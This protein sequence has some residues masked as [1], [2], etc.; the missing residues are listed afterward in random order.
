VKSK[1]VCVS[2][3]ILFPLA[4]DA[5]PMS[6]NNTQQREIKS[7][8]KSFEILRYIKQLNGAKVSELTELTDLTKGTVHTHLS[9]LMNLEYVTQNDSEYHLTCQFIIEGEY[10]RNHNP[11]FQAGWNEINKLA[12]ETGEFVHLMAEHAGGE[13]TLHDAQGEN[14]IATDYRIQMRQE[15]EHL[16][17]T[18]SGKAILANLPGERVSEIIDRRGIP[19]KTYNTITDREKLNTELEQIREQGYAT[20]EEEEI[21]GIVAVGVP[22]NMK[23]GTVLAALSISAPSSR[24]TEKKLYETYPEQ[25]KIRKQK[26][27]EKFDK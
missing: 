27:E 26:I 25:L 18:A 3:N 5:S 20:N 16:H 12:I 17:C 4:E 6:G 9:T 24:M 19:E 11:V 10:V 22:I 14:A 8:I 2:T 23:N 1:R 7:V 15:V 21:S 13:I